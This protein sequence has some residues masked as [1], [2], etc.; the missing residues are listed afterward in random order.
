MVYPSHYYSYYYNYYD[1]R[2]IVSHA[3][4][5]VRV[6]H[7][8]IQN[9]INRSRSVQQGGVKYLVYWLKQ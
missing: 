9:L 6:K 1:T 2:V 3:H 5:G 7:K 4:K 8:T